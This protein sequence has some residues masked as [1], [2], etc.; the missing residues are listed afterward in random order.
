MADLVGVD[1]T[2]ETIF[3][4]IELAGLGPYT[5]SSL[6]EAFQLEQGV[7]GDQTLTLLGTD[8]DTDGDGLRDSFENEKLGS[9][10]A[11]ASGDPDGDGLTNLAE[12]LGSHRSE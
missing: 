5:A 2:G 6:L 12:Q 9:L 7:T 3:S 10:D 4:L 11:T 8:A 1:A